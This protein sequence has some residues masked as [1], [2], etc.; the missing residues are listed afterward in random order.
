MWTQERPQHT[1]MPLSN[2]RKMEKKSV[3][4]GKDFVSILTDLS[5]AFDSLDHNFK[6]R[7]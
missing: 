5:R 6:L 1:T 3:D 2:T 4:S 7:S